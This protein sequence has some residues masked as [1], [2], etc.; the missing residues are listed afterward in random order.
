MSFFCS[1]LTVSFMRLID[2]GHDKKKGIDLK[3]TLVFSGMGVFYIGPALHIHYSKILPFFVPSTAS[4][5]A[6]R[7]LIIDQSLFAPVLTSGFFM[8]INIA[9]GNGWEKGVQALRE[10][11]WTTLL[12]NW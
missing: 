2:L 10:K 11:L 3:R 9:E 5:G 7:K 12:V 8:I 1:F 4:F 6:V